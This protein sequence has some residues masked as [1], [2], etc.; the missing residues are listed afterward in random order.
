[1][2]TRRA[3]PVS[4][5][6]PLAGEELQLAV[7]VSEDPLDRSLRVATATQNFLLV[8]AGAVVALIGARTLRLRRHRHR[9]MAGIVHPRAA[10]AP[11]ETPFKQR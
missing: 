6:V 11:G 8:I 2:P 10:L 5:S 7:K 4:G 3:G 9:E 1:M